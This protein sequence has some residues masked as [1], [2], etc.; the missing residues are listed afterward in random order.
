MQ[1]LASSSGGQ[2]S[3]LDLYHGHYVAAIERRHGSAGGNCRSGGIA[4]AVNNIGATPIFCSV[5]NFAQLRRK[6]ANSFLDGLGNAVYRAM[7]GSSWIAEAG[8]HYDMNS[9]LYPATGWANA[10]HLPYLPMILPDDL[11]RGSIDHMLGIVISKGPGAGYTLP[12]GGGDGNGT[13]GVPMGS[14]LRLRADFDMSGYSASS[15]VVLRALQQHGA[16]IYDST[17]AGQD[18]AKLLAMSNGWAGT[19]YLTAQADLNKVPMSA[20]EVVDLFRNPGRSGDWLAN[21]PVRTGSVT[22][23]TTAPREVLTVATK[24]W[25]RLLAATDRPHSSANNR[26]TAEMR[27]GP[28]HFAATA[29]AVPPNC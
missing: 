5:V 20:F 16:V 25:F 17:T 10:S 18:G 28:A 14:V 2:F 9:G 3:T 23:E 22:P 27:V 11:A 13:N 7:Y 29:G 12:A 1:S 26:R 6:D 15:Q 8:V 4:L 21:Q 24:R 19:E